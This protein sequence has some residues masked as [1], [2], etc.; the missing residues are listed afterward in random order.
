MPHHHLTVKANYPLLSNV[1]SDTLGNNIV[2]EE[3]LFK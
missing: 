3:G 1:K 2:V